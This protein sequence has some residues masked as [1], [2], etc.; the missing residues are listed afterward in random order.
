VP[1]ALGYL[2]IAM[3]RPNTQT[4]LRRWALGLPT[5]GYA[6]G[7]PPEPTRRAVRAWRPSPGWAAGILAAASPIGLNGVSEFIYLRF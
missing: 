6:T 3:L 7:I 5:S 4:L 2:A 1:A